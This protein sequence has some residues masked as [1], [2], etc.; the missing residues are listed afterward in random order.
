MKHSFCFKYTQAHSN[1]YSASV[2]ERSEG[3]RNDAISKCFKHSEVNKLRDQLLSFPPGSAGESSASQCVPLN[4]RCVLVTTSLNSCCAGQDSALSRC[5][6]RSLL[7][8]STNLWL[9]CTM[10]LNSLDV[11]PSVHD[12]LLSLKKYLLTVTK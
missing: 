9:V 6:G 8:R 4:G 7:S 10:D 1:L 11:A 12:S 3:H 5:R 2:L